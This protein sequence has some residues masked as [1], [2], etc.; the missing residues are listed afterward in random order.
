[1]GRYGARDTV[2][3]VRNLDV[4][5]FQR[6]RLFSYTPGIR[7]TLFWKRE[8]ET[9]ASIGWKLE[10]CC[11]S[12]MSI[13]LTYTAT[14]F[15]E[16]TK[17]DYAVALETTPCNYGG[18]RWWFV[19]PLMKN[20]WPC[21]RRCRFL[22]LPFGSDYF[23]CRVCYDLAYES[24]QKSGSHFYER[25]ARPFAVLER[26]ERKLKRVRS[27]GSYSVCRPK[28]IGLS[29]GSQFSSVSPVSG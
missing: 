8:E 27:P 16:E 22:Y 24:S 19:C 10:G 17:C 11:G 3:G 14:H 13:R 1:M 15:S 9:V 2:D 20:G 6:H 26:C 7:Y 4:R 5:Y 12:P 29:V 21:G 18:V 25:M 28:W 23:G